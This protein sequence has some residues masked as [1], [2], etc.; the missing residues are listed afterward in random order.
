[1]DLME[2]LSLKKKAKSYIRMVMYLYS[3][4]AFNEENPEQKEKYDNESNRHSKL[5]KSMKWMNMEMA[6]PIVAEYPE[7][8]R[9][10]REKE[11]RSDA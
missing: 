5:L 2:Y 4:L 1:M 9:Q 6:K 7:L 8:I 10:L 11:K 3:N